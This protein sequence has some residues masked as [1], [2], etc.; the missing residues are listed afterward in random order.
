M[1][2]MFAFVAVAAVAVVLAVGVIVGAPVIGTQTGAGSNPTYTLSTYLSSGCNDIDLLSKVELEVQPT[3]LTFNTSGVLNNCTQFLDCLVNITAPSTFVDCLFGTGNNTLSYDAVPA[4]NGM[5]VDLTIY[6][7]NNCTGDTISSESIPVG[8]CVAN[9][10]GCGDSLSIVS[11][12][13]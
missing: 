3:C 4:P 8:A 12:T 6:S 1:V 13:D 5:Y 2:S 11:D 7:T 9:T 10:G